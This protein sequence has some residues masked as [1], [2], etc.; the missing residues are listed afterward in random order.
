MHAVAGGVT[1]CAVDIAAGNAQT[2]AAAAEM[3]SQLIQGYSAHS[4]FAAASNTA[5][6]EHKTWYYQRLLFRC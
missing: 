6:L 2:A 4:W 3:L 1:L 5:A